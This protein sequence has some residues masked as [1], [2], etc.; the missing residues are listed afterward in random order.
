VAKTTSSFNS[1]RT[2][3]Q[4]AHGLLQKSPLVPSNTNCWA[5]RA[6]IRQKHPYRSFRLFLA[7]TYRYIQNV[8]D[9]RRHT[10]PKAR[11][12]VR[13]AKKS[14]RLTR[15]ASLSRNAYAHVAPS[16]KSLCGKTG[17]QIEGWLRM[18]RDHAIHGGPKYTIISK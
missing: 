11:P 6:K 13:S 9:D 10:V 14:R 17:K 16:S 3:R 18:S 5:V 7:K 4:Y 2:I 15:R 12:I 1:D 8:T